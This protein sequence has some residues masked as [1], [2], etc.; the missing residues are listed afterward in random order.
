MAHVLIA[1]AP[2]D[3]SSLVRI[4]DGHD[5]IFV[6]TFDKAKRLLEERQ[7]DLIIAGLHFDESRMFEVVHQAQH[8]RQNANR[9]VICFN[10]RKTNMAKLMHNSLQRCSVALGASMYLDEHTYNDCQDPD[11]ELRRV[12]EQCISH[13]LQND[14]SEQE[15]NSL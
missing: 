3:A 1:K 12:I 7:F 4:L 8:S 14:N 6:E 10:S 5:L 11:A 9:P 13:E 15:L 2:N